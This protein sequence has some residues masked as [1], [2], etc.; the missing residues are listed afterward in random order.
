MTPRF[1]HFLPYQRAWIACPAPMAVGEKARRIGWTYASAFRAVQRRLER[2]TDL[3]YTSA[4]LSAAR[5]FVEECQ[6]WARAFNEVATDLGSQVIDEHD[7]IT[8]FVLRFRS[9]AKI[10]AGSSNPKFFRS[11]GGDADADEFAFHADGRNLLKAMHATA[12]V[13]GHQLRLWS[14]HNG[15][16]SFF[17]QLVKGRDNSSLSH[18]RVTIFDAVEQGLV[19]R[20]KGLD[21]PD[22][23]A[24]RDWLEELRASCPD[25]DTWREE[26]LC[27]PSSEQSAL[28]TY[29]MIAA[30]EGSLNPEPRTVNPCYAGF[31]VG[32]KRDCSVLW[33]LERVG[34]VFHTRELRVLESTP[35][36]EQEDVLHALLRDPSVKRLCVDSTGIG[37]MLAER[38][39]QRWGYRVEGVPFT[40]SSK[41]ALAMPLVRL[42]QDKLIRIPA[43]PA[44]REDLHKV[45][46][47]VTA[48][49]NI[50]FDATRDEAGHAD[51]FWALALAH[52]AADHAPARMLTLARKPVGW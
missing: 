44:V 29:S 46:K 23:V 21:A 5:E 26:Y 13:W 7:G 8:A 48:A 43:D 4:D 38:L 33:V 35:F 52:H 31:D 12:M 9:G 27:E 47:T 28:L 37:A 51:R 50:R 45:R 1:E 20:I 49:G 39:K 14:T 42:F 3:F 32:R 11:K 2:E 6:R 24:R 16:A 10:V 25:E 30:C 18:F 34:D 22:P 19:E 40:T 41:S 15:E 17:N 36:T